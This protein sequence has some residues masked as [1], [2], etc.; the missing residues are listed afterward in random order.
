[1]PSSTLTLTRTLTQTYLQSLLLYDQQTG[2]FTWRV[3]RGHRR[4]KGTRAGCLD[5][6]QR[7]IGIDGKYYREHQLAF[8]YMTVSVPVEIDHRNLDSTDNCWDNLREATHAQNCANRRLYKRNKSGRKGVTLHKSGKWLAGLRF[9]G[10][11]IYLGV[12]EHK[13]D[14]ANAYKVKA[15]EIF[16]EFANIGV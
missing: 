2:V 13:E 7:I 3:D 12:F 10:N 11:Y 15:L 14:A 8:L 6:A 1:M 9:H 16:G 4:L 5:G